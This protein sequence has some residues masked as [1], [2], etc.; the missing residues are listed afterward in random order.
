MH[1][2][3][4]KNANLENCE[5]FKPNAEIRVSR[6]SLGP[7][8][9]VVSNGH[10]QVL[11]MSDRLMHDFSFQGISDEIAANLIQVAVSQPM[12]RQRAGQN[13]V[14]FGAGAAS[15]LGSTIMKIPIAFQF[16]AG[17]SFGEI[18]TD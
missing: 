8:A 16:R 12:G 5:V 10:L 17:G 3:A 18:L 4:Q 9:P 1:P 6:H 11:R 7:G 13:M 15:L 14:G 2:A